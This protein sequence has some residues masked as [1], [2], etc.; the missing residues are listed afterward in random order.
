MNPDHAPCLEIVQISDCHLSENP[1][2][3]YRGEPGEA[4]LRRLVGQIADRQPDLIM[5]TG[6]LSEDASEASYRRLSEMLAAIDI[7]VIALPG[8][9][10]EPAVMRKFFSQGP[11]H[12][13]FVKELGTWRVILLNS[14]KPGAIEGALESTAL[15]QLQR[16]L[17]QKPGI[18]T[19]VALHH[20]PVPV[21]ASWID[22]YRLD[23]PEGLFSVIDG[24]EQVK[25]V[26]WGHI[27]HAF[28]TER[29]GVKLLGAPSTAVNSLPGTQKFT[30]DTAGP[31]CRWLKMSSDGRVETGLV[32]LNRG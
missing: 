25:V 23:C 2:T 32:G 5:A 26:V 15:E 18:P 10:D 3:L 16:V 12:G 1:Q 27:H 21:N 11:W 6:D 28:E 24:A 4:H 19:L 17:D 31:S 7:P 30:P 14:K 13:P 22:R 29:R 9:H 20:Q 8:N